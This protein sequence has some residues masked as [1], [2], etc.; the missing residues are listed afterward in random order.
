VVNDSNSWEI[1]FYEESGTAKLGVKNGSESE[2]QWSELDCGFEYDVT[3]DLTR[4][5]VGGD[6]CDGIQ[7]GKGVGSSF[8][9]RFERGHEAVGT[10]NVTVNTTDIESINFNGHGGDSPRELDAVY[11]VRYDVMFE[12][13]YLRYEKSSRVARGEPE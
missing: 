3:V 2:S 13:P 11:S 5:E 9:I 6:S 7:F 8:D 1:Y 10:Y 12:N 4:G